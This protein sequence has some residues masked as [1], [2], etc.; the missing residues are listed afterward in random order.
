MQRI[1][2]TLLIGSLLSV[3][4]FALD[5]VG[6]WLFD[7]DEG[8]V[9]KDSSGNENHGQI[10]G[11]EWVE[12]KIGSALKFG[13]SAYVEVPISDSMAEF[14]NEITFMAWIRPTQWPDWMKIAGMGDWTDE[15]PK[16]YQFMLGFA[17]N[18]GEIKFY[19]GD[20]TIAAGAAVIE[21]DEWQH[22]ACVSEAGKRGELYV[23]G[24]LIK[25]N[26][27]TAVMPP[28]E[29]IP[30]Y[31]GGAFR[32]GIKTNFFVGD[33]DEAALFNVALSADEVKLYMGGLKEI[34]EAVTPE[35]KLAATW[36]SI[37][38]R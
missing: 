2:V 17:D 4:A 18:P 36:G 16:P 7:D 11:G 6:I 15:S 14:E 32:R 3:N 30:L 9:L 38:G 33:M 29:D 1:L 26:T 8:S 10:T 37:K 25:Q 31:I 24:Q 21:L 23:D 13:N 20:T 34:S 5:A 19:I 12:G 28:P 27:A 22:V 35:S